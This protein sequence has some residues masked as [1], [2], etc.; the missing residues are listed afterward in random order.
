MRV[1]AVVLCGAIVGAGLTGL[2]PNGV[3]PA[4]AATSQ[5]TTVRVAALALPSDTRAALT[6]SGSSTRTAGLGTVQLAAVTAASQKLPTFS[7][8]GATLPSR[9]MKA[10]DVQLRV[11]NASG[12]GA[13][14][15]LSDDDSGPDTDTAEGSRAAKVNATA[16]IWVENA[17][18][19][20]TRLTLRTTAAASIATKQGIKLTMVDPGNLATD[21]QTGARVA[22]AGQPAIISRAGWGANE[23]IVCPDRDASDQVSLAVVH[24]TAGSNNYR[25]V[26]EAKRQLRADY[27][28]HVKGRGWCDLGYNFVV[29]K[30]GNIYE[31][32]RGSIAGARVGAHAAGFNKMSV[33]IT[34]LGN[35][36][37]RTPSSA[38]RTAVAKVIA[39][40]LSKYGRSPL[41]TVNYY[42]GAGSPKF[43]QGTLVKISR[44]TGHRNVGLTTCPG[45][46]GYA[47]LPSIRRSAAAIAWNANWVR[48]SYKDQLG[49]EADNGAAVY[50][51]GVA[52]TQGREAYL[53]QLGVVTDNRRRQVREVFQTV[54]GREPAPAE[55]RSYL[56]QMAVR[57]R[58][59]AQLV[60]MLANGREIYANSGRSRAGYTKVLVRQ[61]LG[62][63]AR[64]AEVTAW[65][66][67]LRK[68]TRAQMADRLYRSPES[69]R[70]RVDLTS[71]ALT[72][73]QATPAQMRILGPFVVQRGDEALRRNF[74]L[75]A[76]YITTSQ[77]R[78]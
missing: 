15:T 17:T 10:S 1:A 69:G 7:L 29:D 32:R 49:R 45:T 26:A 46:R 31:G 19:V 63:E 39:W 24:H 53:Q 23:K 73:R 56:S 16:P 61:L 35:Y 78:Y 50:W 70:H 68:H 4:E 11:R 72:G 2:G 64:P 54:L 3:A 77:T 22:G 55:M 34:M 20:Q 13:W 75:S 38:T 60:V 25:T 58:S 76:S 57:K 36:S 65:V 51:T 48:A 40:K 74:L 6:S 41:S 12:W 5:G 71:R 8:V 18:A 37:T 52:S 33:G 67:Y 59:K 9:A 30:W 43:K 66:G 44:V 28:Y 27:A 42:A 14:Q 21:D 62:R 47:Q